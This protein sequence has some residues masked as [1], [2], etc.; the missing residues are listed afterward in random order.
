M[1]KNTPS[2]STK[3]AT[4]IEALLHLLSDHDPRIARHIHQHLVDAGRE[5]MPFLRA[6][7]NDCDDPAL[8]LRIRGVIR[9]IAQAD[10]EQEWS[11]LLKTS[12]P[13][14][15]LETGAFLIARTGDPHVETAPYR[16][17][18]DAIA[19]ELKPLSSGPLL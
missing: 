11:A 10:V 12:E 3:R 6:A 15:D 4:N 16:Q 2:S 19:A 8:A 13:E 18:L 17:R 1:I 7:L 5:A 14:L 9:E